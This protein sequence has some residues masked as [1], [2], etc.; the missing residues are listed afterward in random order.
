MQQKD[1]ILVNK[2][3]NRD[4]SISKV[5][6]SN[7]WENVNVRIESREHGTTLAV[8]NE[9]GTIAVDSVD[10]TGT[11][12]GANVLNNHLIVFTHEAED[13]RPD[14]IWLCT[15]ADG[16]FTNRVLYSGRLNFDTASP[17][18][19]VVYYESE[20]VQKIYW[21]DGRNPLRMLNFMAS[22]AILEECDANS[23]DVNRKITYGVVAHISKDNSGSPRANGTVQYLLTYYDEYGAESGIAWISDLVYLSPFGYGGSADGYNNNSVKIVFEENSLDTTFTTF[24]VYSIFRS[25]EDGTATAYRIGDFNTSK[26]EVIVIDNG[27]HQSVEDATALLYLGSRPVCPGTIAHKDQTLFLGDLKGTGG[28]VADEIES[29]IREQMFDFGSDSGFVENRTWKSKCI[30]FVY[31]DN[32]RVD[33]SDI[34]LEDNGDMYSYEN[35]LQL[36]SSQILSF[37]GGEKYRF[38][39]KFR[40]QDGSET[41]AFWIGDAI[42]DKYPVM[43]SAHSCVKRVVAKCTI[44]AGLAASLRTRGC[45]AA[46][47]LIAEA[48]AADRSV[49]A[50]GIVNPTVF[51]A[52]ERAKGRL[53]A[54]PSWVS[55]PINSRLAFS[56]FDAIHSSGS[57]DG[58]IQCNW[59]S[60]VST[61][62]PYYRYKKDD[63]G[64][65]KVDIATEKDAF[66]YR[67]ILFRVSYKQSWLR[68][69]YQ[70][71]AAIIDSM[72]RDVTY[73]QIES[74]DTSS[75]LSKWWSIGDKARVL[76]LS[77]TNSEVGN[78][79][80]ARRGLHRLLRTK[81]N[82]AGI[83]DGEWCV[84]SQTLY[85]MCET[86]FR[87]EVVFYNVFN[88]TYTTYNSYKNAFEA[89]GSDKRWR[90]TNEEASADY[91]AGLMVASSIKNLMFVDENVVTLDS[92]ELTYDAVRIDNVD[93]KFRIVGAAKMKSVLSDYTIDASGSLMPGASV[94]TKDMSAKDV[95]YNGGIFSY[96]LWREFGLSVKNES[97]D[98]KIEDRTSSD[99]N[100]EK[101]GTAVRYWLNMWQSSGNITKFSADEYAG[102]SELKRKVFA[103]M[104]IAKESVFFKNPANFSMDSIRQ[105]FD[106]DDS[107]LLLK[108]GEDTSY[109]SGMPD[110]ILSM[111][112]GKK[113]PILYSSDSEEEVS[114]SQSAYLYSDSPVALQYRTGNH[115]VIALVS[116]DDDPLSYTQ[117]VLPRIRYDMEDK[118]IYDRLPY[119][120]NASCPILPWKE[121]EVGEELAFLDISPCELYNWDYN[122][123]DFKLPE[124]QHDLLKE[125]LQIRNEE[126]VKH[127]LLVYENK[128]MYLIRVDGAVFGET[129][130]DIV[131][132]PYHEPI[133]KNVPDVEIEEV[134]VTV[135]AY[136]ISGE[137]IKDDGRNRLNFYFNHTNPTYEL[138]PMTSWP[139]YGLYA[140][141]GVNFGEPN[142]DLAHKFDVSDQ[143]MFIGELYRDFGDNDTRYGGITKSAI[144]TN[145]F[146]AA[147]PIR[148][149]NSTNKG[150]I[151]YG[152]QGDTYFQRFDALRTKPYSESSENNVLDIVSVML[153]TH[154]NLDGRT[155]V[156]RAPKELA[157]IDYE[158]YAQINSVY[159]QRN[160]FFVSNDLPDAF[161]RDS[162]RSSVTWT[163]PKT[164][165]APV[166]NW[167]HITLANVLDLDG[168]KG[169]CR[170]IKRFGNTLIAFQDRGVSEILFNS[171]TQL[172]T[173][174]G[175][176]IEL[177]NSGKVEG[178]R[179]IT[180]KYGC[181]NK[182]S[183]TEGK[184]ALYFVDNINKAF[185]AF[186]G[187]VEN[188]SLKLHFSSWFRS[189]N[190]ML[191]WNPKLN[192]NFRSFYDRIHN[193]VYVLSEDA[194]H[195]ALVYNEGLGAFTSFFDYHGIDFM[196]NI[197]DEFV[198]IH[199]KK[200]YLQNKGPYNDFFGEKFPSEIT[201]RVAPDP[202]LDKVWTNMDV[203]VDFYDT[204]KFI[205]EPENF[206]TP[207]SYMPEMCFD[208]LSI[209]NEYQKANVVGTSANPKKRFRTW[210]YTM[211]RASKTG[212][213]KFGLD[214]FRNPWIFVKF[215][216]NRFPSASDYLMQ[217]HEIVIK[218]FE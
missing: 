147:G 40:M 199:G 24:R 183:I 88:S 207:E 188:L 49:L 85:T 36:T 146:I 132:V 1:F 5:G 115:A 104:N 148:T 46:Q 204:S 160:N 54:M 111:P 78:H 153:E 57:T 130:K 71:T 90:S 91:S 178:K 173:E 128:S 74:A 79:G 154:I 177:A 93:C 196:T 164:D 193:D 97:K 157:S 129:A 15:F 131:T 143:Y 145:R 75:G 123:W 109:Y 100:I 65:W 198:S 127:C 174:E 197:E 80:S 26:T 3:M 68:F 77:A 89:N 27:T 48:T 31:S 73:D 181:L 69:Q 158:N 14:T 12:I 7:A 134:F 203:Q 120:Q 122:R 81:F 44:S 114:D 110:T 70:V 43:D 4:V 117:Q 84:S 98:T 55:R 201:Y 51:N 137:K 9:R 92:P 2:G 195:P 19:S 176:P 82:E 116:D 67:M 41:D 184:S 45:E 179:Y 163:L 168:D 133:A 87:N 141:P 149:L 56:H 6:G 215:T 194:E 187:S 38:A 189:H 191:P 105:V 106:T 95:S 139:E 167:T 112:T 165:L 103:N 33:I 166:D 101:G 32:S 185:C 171:R 30:E 156:Q 212:T 34:P 50:Q 10:L 23:F 113:Y 118:W 47:L 155:D 170:S 208:E 13:F 217:L 216:K 135:R 119:V 59:W 159:G 62:T 96:P 102:H 161:N 28:Y 37:K 17:I 42:N 64:K 200:L 175:V 213:N 8:T 11:A 60:G 136:S 121:E 151:L 99:Y 22:E 192:N 205:D 211:P 138:S 218:Y 25:S 142:S 53:Y 182:W 61:P 186:N 94:Y 35:Q 210:H 206:I 108:V 202:A 18:E 140:D 190:D 209:W 144:A 76:N 58:E 124:N 86:A 150:V 125:F 63:S 107:Q 152:N 52:Y 29:L 172:S 16:K 83:N 66:L 126:N 72:D 180:E 162:Y 169:V 39:L 21:V 214:H 20:D